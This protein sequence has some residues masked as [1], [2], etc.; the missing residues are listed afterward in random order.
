MSEYFDICGTHIPLST[1]K[2]FRI[3]NVEF[4]FRPVFRESERVTMFSISKK[5]YEF[6]HMEPFA[7]I[8]D[9]EISKKRWG[10]ILQGRLSIR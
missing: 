4:I 8:I 9:R 6:S 7:A 10:K 3:I 2:D 1:I 5:K